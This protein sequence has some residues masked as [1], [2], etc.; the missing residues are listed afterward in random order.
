LIDSVPYTP[1]CVFKGMDTKTPLAHRS[2]Q[3]HS[4]IVAVAMC[5]PNQAMPNYCH[6]GPMVVPKD[7]HASRLVP[8]TGR[9]VPQ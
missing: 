9:L 6:A 1:P 2:Y 7:R 3:D 4:H 8:N 5:T